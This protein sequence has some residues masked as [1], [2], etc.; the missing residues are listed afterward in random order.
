[1]ADGD[2]SA[3]GAVKIELPFRIAKYVPVPGSSFFLPLPLFAQ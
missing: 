1:M 2:Y 3:G